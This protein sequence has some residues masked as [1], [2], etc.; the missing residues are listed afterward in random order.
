M[1]S[2]S[3]SLSSSFD[4]ELAV[5]L[6][7]MQQ[8]P[9]YDVAVC[10]SC[11]Y[12][13]VISER[14]GNRVYIKRE[15][16]QPTFSFKLRG[17]YCAMAGLPAG[18][19]VIAASAGNHAQGVALAAQ[20][21]GFSAT[22]VVPTTT[23]DVKQNAICA[24]GAEL[25]LHGDSYD[26]A[27]MFARSRSD[28]EGLKFIHPYDDPD[29]IVGQGTI[30]VELASQLP[31]GTSKV[32]VA[33]GGGGLISG[34]ALALRSLRPEI[35]VIG[36]EPEDSDAM[37]QSLRCGSR[38]RL[39]R[40][41]IFA[42]GVAVKQVGELP[43]AILSHLGVRVITV[44]NDAICAA[45][46][47]CFEDRRAV[48]EPAGALAVA[49]LR[50]YVES[51]GIEGET[52]AAIACGANVNFDRLGFIA[53]RAALGEH[54]EAIFAVKIPER[55]GAFRSLCDTLQNRN[56]TE[57]NY[58]MGDADVAVV[59]VGVRTRSLEDSRA[60][61]S[62]LIAGE[63][64]ATDLSSNE[65][66]KTHVRHMV[67]GKSLCATDERL[68]HFDFPERPG[69]LGEFLRHLAGKWNISLFHYRNHGADR[70]RV[71]VGIQVP[72]ATHE[73][74]DIFLIELG[75]AYSEETQNPALRLFL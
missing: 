62:D 47:E 46:K 24:L 29:V 21:L 55:P 32:F 3:P 36:V 31:A 54:T 41:G 72:A 25:I 51:S 65:L 66:A 39:E 61:L 53:E 7:R 63:Y 28:A 33:I 4:G 50:A 57:F 45:V 37:S 9:V 23:P 40:V 2:I 20:R 13:P 5:L 48:L 11:D 59:F 70:G 56:I 10:S 27:Y 74:F 1:A 71:L 52:L 35:E 14:L 8:S 22:I 44:S 75:Y 73:A 15:D 69:A 43:F 18:S 38:V 68:F 12:A 26:D 34:V 58:R 19:R 42:D 17:A 30:G 16:T 49:G 6:Q 64:E 67:G 60:I